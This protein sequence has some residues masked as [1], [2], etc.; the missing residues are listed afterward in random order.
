[1]AE[2]EKTVMSTIDNVVDTAQNKVVKPAHK[3]ARFSVYGFVALV[4]G[5]VVLFLLTIAAFRA[6]DIVLPTYAVYLV[7]GGI[8]VALGT[9]LWI[10]K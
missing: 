7:W 3:L 9:L 6:T 2:W 1:M 5:L 8:F 10:K 4:L